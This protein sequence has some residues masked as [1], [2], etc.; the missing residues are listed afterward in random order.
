MPTPTNFKETTRRQAEWRKQKKAFKRLSTE[1]EK[2]EFLANAEPFAREFLL[3][4]GGQGYGWY[5]TLA[6][7][8]I[9]D[10]AWE[11]GFKTPEEA[12]AQALLCQAEHAQK[13]VALPA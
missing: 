13:L 10:D 1:R 8:P 12:Y 7:Y 11:Q 2:H 3:L 9:L 4:Q 5:P 6:G